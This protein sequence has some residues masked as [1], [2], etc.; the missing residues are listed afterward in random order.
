MQRVVGTVLTA[1]RIVTEPLCKGLHL[2]MF[3]PP[4]DKEDRQG[5]ESAYYWLGKFVCEHCPMQQKCA[6]L[7][8]DEEFGL[9]GGMTPKERRTGRM[10][11]NKSR[12]EPSAI[13]HLPPTDPSDHLDLRG[14]RDAMR[15][16]L[17]RRKRS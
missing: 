16:H 6:E 4:I 17:K 8:K 13:Q 9:W 11:W 3:Y 10:A 1:P 15:K 5:P 2:E 14:T 7:G 12:I